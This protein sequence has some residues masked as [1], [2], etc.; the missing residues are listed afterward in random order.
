[1]KKSHLKTAIKM[2]IIVGGILITINQLDVILAGDMTVKT[3]IKVIMTPVVPF[4]VSLYSA[5]VAE[6]AMLKEN[7]KE[8]IEDNHLYENCG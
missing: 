5:I 1:M 7:K 3:W 2:S 8:K 4:C 6:K